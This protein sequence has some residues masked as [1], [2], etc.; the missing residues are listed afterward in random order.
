[1]NLFK[2][3]KTLA[4][5]ILVLLAVSLS[6]QAAGEVDPTFNPRLIDVDYVF[7]TGSIERTSV[8]R[9]AVQPDGKILATGIFN[10]VENSLRD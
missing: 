4:Q 6:A 8:K 1:M 9:V 3:I 10:V 2:H 7:F 5:T